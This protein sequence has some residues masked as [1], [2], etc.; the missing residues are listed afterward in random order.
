MPTRLARGAEAMRV[1]TLIGLF[2]A[3][4]LVATLVRG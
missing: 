1:D 3:V 2:L 4:L